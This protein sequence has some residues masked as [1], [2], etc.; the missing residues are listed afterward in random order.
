MTQI[1]Y[2]EAP[3]SF[4]F[5]D[6]GYFPEDSYSRQLD[7]RVA[8]QEYPYGYILHE[9]PAGHPN[10]RKDAYAY[11]DDSVHPQRGLPSENTSKGQKDFPSR[12]SKMRI[13]MKGK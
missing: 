13:P 11:K 6:Q 3:M 1:L 2:P 12:E 4:N 5:L 9:P 8:E 7:R 10:D